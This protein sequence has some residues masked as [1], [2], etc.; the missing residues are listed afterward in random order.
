[1]AT[2][3]FTEQYARGREPGRFLDRILTP[4]Q[5]ALVDDALRGM[6]EV[7]GELY[8]NPAA[9]Q[10]MLDDSDFAVLDWLVAEIAVDFTRTGK[11]VRGPTRVLRDPFSNKPFVHFYATRGDADATKA[12]F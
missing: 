12:T 11:F 7:A 3:F 5:D 8:A 1:M 2:G 4:E 9:S 6:P 10:A